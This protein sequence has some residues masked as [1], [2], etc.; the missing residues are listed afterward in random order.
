LTWWVPPVQDFTDL[1]TKLPNLKK[2]L[3][4][5]RAFRDERW[6]EFA[7]KAGVEAREVDAIGR[8]IA[9]FSEAVI[10]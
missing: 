8:D 2:L 9:I 5:T 7:K 4:G 3:V 1:P 6:P 10:R